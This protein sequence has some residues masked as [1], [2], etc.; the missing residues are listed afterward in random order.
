MLLLPDAL[1]H[2]QLK[3]LSPKPD[4][5][6]GL[7][8]LSLSQGAQGEDSRLSPSNPSNVH[9][10]STFSLLYFFTDAAENA[11]NY[12]SAFHPS[13]HNRNRCNPPFRDEWH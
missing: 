2:G 11:I 5:R 7:G 6:E 10:E 9:L 3:F 8:R 1:E 12:D 4:V 13:E